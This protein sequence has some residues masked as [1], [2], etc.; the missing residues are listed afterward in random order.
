MLGAWCS[1]QKDYTELFHSVTY[2]CFSM[3]EGIFL[4]LLAV[5]IYYP[6]IA[7]GVGTENYCYLVIS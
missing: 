5:F 4:Y 3:V 2:C 1:M 6:D 7:R